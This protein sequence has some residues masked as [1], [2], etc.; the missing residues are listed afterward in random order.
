MPD[1]ERGTVRASVDGLRAQL[2]DAGYVVVPAV[3]DQDDVEALRAAFPRETPGST[4]HVEI[5]DETPHAD[6]WRGLAHRPVVAALL[7]E[8][9]GDHEVRIHGRDPGRGAGEQGLHADLPPGRVRGVESLTLIWMLDELRAENGATRVVP[10][11][12]RG[13]AGVP[14][15]LA[16]PG[17]SHPDEVVIVGRPGD[18]LVFDAHLW[19]RGG[20]NSDGAR[21]RVVQMTAKASQ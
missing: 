7:R 21:R 16:Q 5:D 20:R 10:R 8:M 1:R 2:L 13:A 3:L 11:S 17:T 4:L 9:L 18:V 19:H 12:H 14:R 15:A 6:R